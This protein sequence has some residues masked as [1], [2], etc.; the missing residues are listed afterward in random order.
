VVLVLLIYGVG[1]KYQGQFVVPAMGLWLGVTLS[2]SKFNLKALI[3]AIITTS[4]V[5]LA[6]LSFNRA[7][8]P[9]E[10]HRH[11]WER[12]KLYDLAG[13]SVRLDEN[14]FP[15]FVT[16]HKIFSMEQVYGLYSPE[17]VDELIIGAHVNASLAL[18]KNDTE[19]DILWWTWASAVVKH[20][21][22]YLSHRFSVWF[23]MI[24][25]SPI[26]TKNQLKSFNNVPERVKFILEKT[27][28]F[29]FTIARGISRFIIQLPFLFIYVYWG[30]VLFRRNNPY[31]LPLMMM[32][33]AGLSLLG[34]LFVFSMAADLRYI[35]LTTC[36]LMFSHPLA[37]AALLKDRKTRGEA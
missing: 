17:R 11:F 27:E 3:I 20:P 8:V 12:V 13:M 4:F 2:N 7:L 21:Y 36:M 9:E 35:Y 37:I 25:K 5:I 1:V 15:E 32:N 33:I 14:L 18:T 22:S 29:G 34:C 23:T 26:K 19:R 16:S 10:G 24:S 30:F 6:V 28:K 31:G